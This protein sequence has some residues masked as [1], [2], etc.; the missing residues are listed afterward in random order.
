MYE[1][2]WQ[3]Y[4]LYT[5]CL[6]ID[7][8]LVVAWKCYI[9]SSKQQIN[10]II[11]KRA[12]IQFVL[13]IKKNLLINKCGY[14]QIL[15]SVCTRIKVTFFTKLL[16]ERYSSSEFGS[17]NFDTIS[18]LCMSLV[19]DLAHYIGITFCVTLCYFTLPAV[20]W[21]LPGVIRIIWISS[22]L[23]FGAKLFWF[24]LVW[25]AKYV[26]KS[27]TRKLLVH[28]ICLE[29]HSATTMY[30]YFFYFMVKFGYYIRGMNKKSHHKK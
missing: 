25:I 28:C 29:M 30:I 27:F 4:I 6:K 3:F 9:N 22:K 20:I 15:W 24:E 10:F 1:F 18:L 12:Q 21:L 11:R 19:F 26:W 2:F 8:I 7:Y 13:Y 14:Y 17:S 16:L 23:Q 5:L